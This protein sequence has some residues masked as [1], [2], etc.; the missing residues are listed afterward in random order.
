MDTSWDPMSLDGKDNLLRVVRE[1]AADLIGLASEPDAWD[2]PTACPKWRVADVV[3]HLVDVI[4]GY[5]Q[6]FDAARGA[7]TVAEPLG[8]T[9]MATR[10]DE[11]ARWF[12]D[13]SQP[14]MLDR[15]RGDVDT[16]MGVF[17]GLGPDEWGGL[18]VS[19][20]YMGPVP[21]SFYPAFQLMDY[22]VH[23]WD[24]R[25]G[26]GDRVH[27]VNGDAADLLVP[28]MFILWQ[29]T[30]RPDADTSPL[31]VGVR[32]SGRNG[33]DFRISVGPYGL[34]HG[35]GDI[36]DAAA[37]LEFD[38]AGLVLT[39]F[40]RANCATYRGDGAA[41]DRFLNLFFPI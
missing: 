8:L 17:E 18:M 27:A 30:V 39:A 4:D 3:G 23:A 34:N 14:R 21:A 32:V 24:I 38:P 31:D 7:G 41:A 36:E 13:T 9:D 15:L 33:G 29:S 20:P 1:R 10:L 28:F 25:E 16:V 5:L 6:A 35:R 12:H 26:A 22:T 40:G 11:R 2:A 19:H 37:I